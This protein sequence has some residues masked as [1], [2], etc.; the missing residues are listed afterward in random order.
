[1]HLRTPGLSTHIDRPVQL[2]EAAPELPMSAA[3]LAAETAFSVSRQPSPQQLPTIIVRRSR[4][5]GAEATNVAAPRDAE[6]AAM[7]A[8]ANKGPRIFRLGPSAPPAA[9]TGAAEAGPAFAAASQFTEAEAI[10]ASRR[11]RRVAADQRP[12]P[13]V[14]IFKAL[15]EDRSEDRSAGADNT[16]VQHHAVTRAQLATLAEMLAGVQSVLDDIRRARAFRVLDSEA[17]PARG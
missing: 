4:G 8:G 6:Q 17:D 11:K 9:D 15:V 1:M 5:F 12:G 3:R 2:T 14:Q 10:P 13:V 16:P 7:A